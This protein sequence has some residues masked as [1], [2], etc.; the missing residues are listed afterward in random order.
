MPE[1]IKDTILNL[2]QALAAKKQGTA[3]RDPQELLK[4]LLTKKE[5]RHIKFTYLKAGVLCLDV[6]S[7]VWLYQFNLQKE[8]LLERVRQ[9]LPG[10]K[11]IRF[12][13]GAVK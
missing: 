1:A 5:F 4:K 13:L 2:M 10:V 8:A 9:E 11:N 7:S 3:G 12:R 6:E